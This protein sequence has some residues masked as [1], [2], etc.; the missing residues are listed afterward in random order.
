MILIDLVSE[1]ADQRGL[2]QLD[3][4]SG[5]LYLGVRRALAASPRLGSSRRISG[6]V[7]PDKR[8]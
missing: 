5:G 7:I 2:L 8:A 4:A 1:L 6:D 3:A